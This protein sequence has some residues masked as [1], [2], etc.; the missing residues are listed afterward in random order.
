MNQ[1]RL[2]WEPENK[3][4]LSIIEERISTYMRGKKGG[5]SIL[6][7]GTLLFTPNER[8]HQADAYNAMMEAQF[9]IDFNVVEMKEGGYLV[10][11]HDVLAVFVSVN[12]FESVRR[13][14]ERRMDDLKFPEEHFVFDESHTK[15]KLLVGLYA[16]GK[17]QYDAHHF[18]FY[19]RIASSPY[20]S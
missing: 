2:V 6:G 7:N 20:E 15:E 12:E 19:K 4:P 5:V 8:D 1:Y 17:L 14:I 13:E 3:T 18:L 11:F 16:R 10:Q 9:L